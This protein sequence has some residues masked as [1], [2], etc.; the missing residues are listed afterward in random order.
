MGPGFLLD[1]GEGDR[2]RVVQWIEGD[3]Q[4]SF[5]TGLVTAKRVML[6]VA[7]YRCT[8]CGYLESYARS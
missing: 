6:P 3:P 5:W 4:K 1:R 7:T 2:K 8:G